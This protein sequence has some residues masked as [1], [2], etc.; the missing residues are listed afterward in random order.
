MCGTLDACAPS[1]VT[2]ERVNLMRTRRKGGFTLIELL[3][4][5]AIM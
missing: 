3:V 2:D 1:E 5:I 4:V